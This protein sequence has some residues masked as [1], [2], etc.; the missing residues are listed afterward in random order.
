MAAVYRAFDPYFQRDVA[1]KVLP[2]QLSF[3]EK[4]RVRF[5]R[6]AQTIATLE[7][8][9]IV[10][11]YDFGEVDD[12]PYLVMRLMTGGT[13]TERLKAGPLPIDEVARLLERLA[14]ALDYAHSN[15][16]IHR[17]LKPANILFDQWDK[18]YLSDF[19]IVKL[20]GGAGTTL[21]AT[22][23]M[24][25][26]PK[27]MSPEQVLGTAELD[28]RSDIYALG[29]ILFEM[30]TGTPPYDAT[31]PMGVA[32]KHV[33]EPIPD[34]LEKKHD[35]PP[36]YQSI[37]RR[38]LAKDR[39]RRFA[40]ATEL[41]TA[42]SNLV[43]QPTFIE[44]QVAAPNVPPTVISPTAVSPAITPKGDSEQETH[45]EG[46]ASAAPKRAWLRWAWVPVVLLV[47][48][49][50]VVFLVNGRGPVESANGAGEVAANESDSALVTPA[51][52]A[53]A[54]VEPSA[55]AT[56]ATPTPLPSETPT[57]AAESAA[58]APADTPAATATTQP[59][60]TAEALPEVRVIFSSVNLREG[61][62]VNYD[63]AGYL[64]E[65]DTVTVLARDR[66]DMWYN[67]AQDGA[68]LGWLST[69]VVEPVDPALMGNV[70]VAATIPPAPTPTF[71]PLPTNTVAP[72]VAPPTA[73]PPGG[74]NGGGSSGGGGGQP[75]PTS[76]PPPPPS[77][78]PADGGGGPNPTPAYP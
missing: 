35:L 1:I 37:I 51:T 61:P 71:T 64:R 20:A 44:S 57:S 21:T 2:S 68:A 54:A 26:T 50:L 41:A 74:N 58:A 7:H 22:G 45:A 30:L 49:A 38:A 24:V 16:V 3:D 43:A 62:G 17:D 25:G 73:V 78:T 39:E 12:Q 6:E 23:G 42:V 40:T 53:A 28:G 56:E 77:P 5:K 4:F 31:T 67:V 60:P 48:V 33:N 34:I 47:A 66:R 18:P 69:E 29:V 52:A 9:A 14:P 19:G 59:S 76:P 70:A 8:P 10:P 72:T 55:T 65:G 75:S 63:V 15:N 36:A 27:Y 13:L 32:F 11:V 46:K